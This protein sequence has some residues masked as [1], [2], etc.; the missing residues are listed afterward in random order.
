MDRREL[1]GFLKNRRERV[2]PR[3]VG[4]EAGPRRRTPGLRREEV[5]RLAGMSVDYYIRLEQARGPR[6]SRQVLGA[7]ARALR[8]TDDEREYIFNLAGERAEPPPGPPQEVPQGILQLLDRLDDTPAF[9]QDAKYDVLAWN[10][11]A[12]ALIV[13]FGTL[14]PSD[15][16]PIR[17][18]FQSDPCPADFDEEHR[19]FM[20]AAVG[21]LRAAA[22]RYPGDPGVKRLI[23]E[24]SA[25]SGLFR[26]L[27]DERDVQVRLATR[28]RM[29]HPV[30]GAIEL[31]CNV[32]L[33]PDRDQRVVLCTAA[34]GTSSYEALKLLRVIG[35]QDL[36]G[37]RAAT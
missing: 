29:N 28:K 16:N 13:D 11:L 3:D 27:W 12:A 18:F 21:D 34:P 37:P 36:T 22:G 35:A 32:L 1:A 31:H 20:R 5:A 17:W 33:V 6:P 10:A 8:L 14:K 26:R 4:L 9:V 25:A 19:Q 2:Q 15:R 7:L 24:M 30:L 23:A